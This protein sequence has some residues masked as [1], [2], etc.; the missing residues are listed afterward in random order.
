VDFFTLNVEAN[1][2]ANRPSADDFPPGGFRGLYFESVPEESVP[3][4]SINADAMWRI[5]D[6]TVLLGD[7]EQNL[8]Q[9]ELATSSVGLAVQRDT[10]LAYFL[11]LRYIGQINSTIANFAFNY[12]LSTRYSIVFNQSYSLS[13][14]Q[15][16]QTNVTVIRR[17]DRFFV[18]LSIYYDEIEDNSGFSF[19]IFPEGLG[20]TASTD[21]LQRVFGPQ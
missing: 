12:Q 8:D 18:T 11:G 5:S 14:K 9:N 13:E 6:S 21:Q 7:I 15:N 3:R 4:N 1:F 20:Y 19:G 17:F 16:Q 2:F 10:H